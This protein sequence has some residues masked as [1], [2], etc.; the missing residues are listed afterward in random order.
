MK[1]GRSL[2]NVPQ[3]LKKTCYKN[4]I[5]FGLLVHFQ[6]YCTIYFNEIDKFPT[7]RKNRE[8]PM[9]AFYFRG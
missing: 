3:K 9:I 7:Q 1:L 6:E 2:G 4:S 5:Y 8:N